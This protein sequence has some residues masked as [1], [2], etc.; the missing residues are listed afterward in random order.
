[1][2][3]HDAAKRWREAAGLSR[4]QVGEMVDLSPRTVE[5]YERG[6]YAR[7]GKPVSA[8]AMRRYRRLVAAAVLG[9]SFDWDVIELRPRTV[10][11]L[12]HARAE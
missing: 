6:I 1:M 7:T 2:T 4:R 5:D 8:I 9:L 10:K 3:E 11:I 12:T